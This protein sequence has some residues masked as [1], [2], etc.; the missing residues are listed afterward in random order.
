MPRKPRRV[1][2]RERLLA[3]PPPRIDL[4]GQQIAQKGGAMRLINQLESIL[5]SRPLARFPP[6]FESI[7]DLIDPMEHVQGQP[8][9]IGE[10]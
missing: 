7:A 4:R 5:D 3:T 8:T 2:I 10:G 9:A 1:L 6:G